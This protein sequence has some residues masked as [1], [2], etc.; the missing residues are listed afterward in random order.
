MDTGKTKTKTK[1]NQLRRKITK[2]VVDTSSKN[3]AGGLVLDFED[4]GGV[5]QRLR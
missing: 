5:L 4:P 2:A 3:A 1:I